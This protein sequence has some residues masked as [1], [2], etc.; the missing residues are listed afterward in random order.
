MTAAGATSTAPVPASRALP[1][2]RR[3]AATCRACP[4]WHDAT[5][6]VFGAGPRRARVVLIGEQPGDQEDRAGRP[7]IGPAGHLLD[8]ALEAAGI[9]RQLVYVTNAVKHFKWEP[10]GPRRLHKKPSAREI[11]ACRPWLLAEVDSLDPA[12]LV[13]LGASAAQAVFAHAVPILKQRGTIMPT[14]FGPPA[15]ITLHPSALLRIRDR[16]EAHAAFDQFVR[17]LKGVARLL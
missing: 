4:L 1:T 10:R 14:A 3:A 17:D 11:A 6:T 16:A 2:L 9:D 5:Q 7:F 15:L 13:C 8:R 12:L